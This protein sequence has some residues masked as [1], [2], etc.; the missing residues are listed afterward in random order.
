MAKRFCSWR[1]AF[2]AIRPRREARRACPLPNST[3]SNGAPDPIKRGFRSSVARRAKEEY[4]EGNG[5]RNPAVPA[6]RIHAPFRRYSL[7]QRGFFD[8][9]TSD[10]AADIPASGHTNKDVRPRIQIHELTKTPTT[11][12][13]DQ[14][15]QSTGNY[16][17]A[18]KDKHENRDKGDGQK[19]KEE[20]RGWIQQP[21]P[22]K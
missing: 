8:N 10:P 7:S 1:R 12:S 19:K 5:G 17:G 21:K 2:R 20:G 11:M 15:K 9:L 16:S 4:Q 14:K 13:H 6:S 22:K 3:G 18:K